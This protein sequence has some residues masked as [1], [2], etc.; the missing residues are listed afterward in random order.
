MQMKSR[1]LA[2]FD[3][4]I[5]QQVH[6]TILSQVN[7]SC[8]AFFPRHGA[9][10]LWTSLHLP[11]KHDHKQP[12]ASA[13]MLCWVKGQVLSPRRHWPQTKKDKGRIHD[14]RL[15]T[16][17]RHVI[18]SFE[19]VSIMRQITWLNRLWLPVEEICLTSSVCTTRTTAIIPVCP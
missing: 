11:W 16:I 19:C 4:L 9:L 17:C 2:S 14:S 6:C 12:C 18:N 15:L 1:V 10:T 13:C 5:R 8:C 3:R 7:Q